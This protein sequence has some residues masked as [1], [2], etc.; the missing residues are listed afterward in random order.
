MTSYTW[1]FQNF[2]SV[3]SI[4]VKFDICFLGPWK[5]Q[6]RLQYFVHWK[7]KFLNFLVDFVLNL[8]LWPSLIIFLSFAK[9]SIRA[10]GRQNSPTISCELAAFCSRMLEMLSKRPRFQ[11]FSGMSLDPLV[12]H[13]F[14]TCK[15]HL[16]HSFFLHCLLQSFCHLLKTL[17][18]TLMWQCKYGRT[19][20]CKLLG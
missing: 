14:G 8:P 11:I 17:L 9:F 12:T 13:A 7:L 3:F 4:V 19:K 18:K 15:S 6:K 16:W 10:G 20:I 1:N 2:T 5:M